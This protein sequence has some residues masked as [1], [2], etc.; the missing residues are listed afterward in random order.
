M[1]VQ[2]GKWMPERGA[3]HEVV[4]AVMGIVLF[5]LVT[6]VWACLWIPPSL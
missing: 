2:K 6:G 3:M 4:R 5:I 1:D